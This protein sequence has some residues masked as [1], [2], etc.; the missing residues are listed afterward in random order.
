MIKNVA[1]VEF[2]QSHYECITSVASFLQENACRVTIVG[3]NGYE[4]VNSKYEYIDIPFSR[5][6]TFT[7]VLRL[8]IQLKRKKIDFLF[9]NTATGS[10]TKIAVLILLFFPKLI[11]SGIVHDIHK[12]STSFGK[13][14]ILLKLKKV[15]VLSETLYK[16]ITSSTPFASQFSYFYPLYFKATQEKIEKPKD[17]IWVGIPGYVEAKRRNYS[18]VFDI[19]KQLHEKSPLR[20]FFLGS[21]QFSEQELQLEID[22]LKKNFS[23]KVH[24][25][26]TYIDTPKYHAYIKNMD[27]LLPLLNPSFYKNRIS[28][29]FNLACAYKIPLIVASD[30]ELF[31][32]YKENA[33]FFQEGELQHFLPKL[34]KP[35]K[36]FFLEEKWT[37]TFQKERF[38][39]HISI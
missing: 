39:K 15:F 37:Y 26:D 30:F 21:T 3:D 19:I 36:N 34:E 27:Y 28:G 20:F 38:L 23:N 17:E 11:C 16:K 4:K 24:F 5:L 9:F 29:V 35:T 33:F 8:L 32:E 22:V 18:A 7:G 13:R 2:S 1:I 10:H 6:S 31:V 25:W 14:I 12:I